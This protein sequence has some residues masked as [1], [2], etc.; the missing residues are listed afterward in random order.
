[1]TDEKA[2]RADIIATARAMQARNLIKGTSGNVS[3]RHGD[4]F[5]ITPT[6]V[7]YDGLAPDQIVRMNRDGRC[8]GDLLPSSE[9]RFHRAILAAFPHF[10]AVVHTHSPYA[11]AVAVLGRDIP[12]IHYRI[13]VAGGATVPCIPYATFGTAELAE[14]I[15]V[16]MA[17]RRGCLLAH[18][19]VVAAHDTL[20]GAL[21]V[22]ETIEEM[23][24]LYILSHGVAPPPV[25]TDED[26]AIVLDKHKTYGQQ[27]MRNG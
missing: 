6:G 14:K 5:L 11:T 19:G 23:A 15:V 8:D 25:L 24:Q 12:A 21:N 22:A 1:M 26:I 9:W 2:L 20:A 16:A 17:E 13:A 4:G 18:H 7:P 27:P 3:A 10:N